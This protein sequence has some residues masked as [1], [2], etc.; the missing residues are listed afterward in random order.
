MRTDSIN[1]WDIVA[2]SYSA[3][4]HQGK[5]F[6]AQIYLATVKELLG[7]VAGKH[8]LDAGCGDG[9]FSFELAQKGA[10]VTSVDNSDVMLN[11]AKRKHFHSNL[12]YHKMDLTR[13]L[14]FENE[15][16]D[17]VVANML[18][19]DIPE[20]D[21]FIHEVARVLKKPGNF[22]FS[23]THPCFFSGNWEEDENNIKMYKKIGNYLDERVEELNFWGKTL[24]YHR[25]LSRYMD[26]IEKA[27]MYISSFREPVPPRELTELYPEQEYHYRIPSFVVIK[28]KSI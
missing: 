8:V 16:F 15:L 19:M 26:A 9:F 5:N 18:L 11:I 4:N 13:K 21:S 2:E 25:P 7:D 1:H 24:H 10:I 6:H 14:T 23:I 12:Q 22:I 28:A 27:G 17:I 3:E 20:I